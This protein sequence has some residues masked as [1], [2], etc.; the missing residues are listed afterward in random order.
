MR[1]HSQVVT[2]LKDLSANLFFWEKVGIRELYQRLLH[3]IFVSKYSIEECSQ[4]DVT[5]NALLSGIDIRLQELNTTAMQ[6][7]C[8]MF[9]KDADNAHRTTGAG[10][11]GEKWLQLKVFI[12]FHLGRYKEA[13]KYAGLLADVY[14]FNHHHETDFKAGLYN[15]LAA[16]MY[17]IF[18]DV[19]DACHYYN[20]Y[21][22]VN[23]GGTA[24][25]RAANVKHA[26]EYLLSQREIIFG[27][28]GKQAVR[29]LAELQSDVDLHATHEKVKA[30]P[31]IAFPDGYT[32][33]H[34]ADAVANVFQEYCEQQSY[35]DKIHLLG[36][37]ESYLKDHHGPSAFYGPGI[38]A[39]R[40]PSSYLPAI[41]EMRTINEKTDRNLTSADLKML[42]KLD[43][44][45]PEGMKQIVKMQNTFGLLLPI[46]DVP[47]PSFK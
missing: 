24:P 11:D 4:L 14:Y 13:A 12:L 37:L 38:F 46:V 15:L 28:Q 22:D 3:L 30:M 10:Q 42:A 34:L 17:E 35:A 31:D 45:L 26:A 8:V 5:V 27:T 19:S 7:E 40:K 9:A 2:E 18:G 36:R 6:R 47:A 16:K 29:W 21:L 32:E 33:N 41:I 43:S 39:Y 23:S 44:Y 25:E 20:Q 1:S